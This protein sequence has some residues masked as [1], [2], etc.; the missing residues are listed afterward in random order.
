MK[1]VPSCIELSCLFLWT[2]WTW[3]CNIY[4]L[5]GTHSHQFSWITIF[6]RWWNSG[7]VISGVIVCIGFDDRDSRIRL[8]HGSFSS[9]KA[10]MIL[11][12]SAILSNFSLIHVQT[13]YGTSLRMDKNQWMGIQLR[14]LSAA[15]PFLWETILAYS[16]SLILQINF[17]NYGRSGTSFLYVSFPLLTSCVPL[18]FY[19]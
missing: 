9:I 4:A 18:F 15:L 7:G 14:C 10:V 2:C 16:F 11:R 3:W 13:Y 5:W 8:A 6:L 1:T 12:I 17:K 19:K